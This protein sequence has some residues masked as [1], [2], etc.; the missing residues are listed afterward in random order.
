M[1]VIGF[2]LWVTM[3][4][5]LCASA[6]LKPVRVFTVAPRLPQVPR[7]TWRPGP[8]HDRLQPTVP[9]TALAPP[10]ASDAPACGAWLIFMVCASL[11]LVATRARHGAHPRCPL[12]SSRVASMRGQQSGR[13]SLPDSTVRGIASP[14]EGNANF[15]SSGK[16]NEA[17]KTISPE[18]AQSGIGQEILKAPWATL[19]D[20]VRMTTDAVLHGFTTEA[21]VVRASRKCTKQV[22]TLGPAVSD[23]SLIERLFLCGVDVFRLNLSHGTN[24]EKADLIHAIRR[25][26]VRYMHPIGI[27][28]DLQ[29]PKQRCG[30]FA[31]ARGTYLEVG[32]RFRFDLDPTPGDTTRV[33]LPH[34]EIL[35]ALKPGHILLL[36]DGK[37][38]T[39]V[40]RAGYFRGGEERVFEGSRELPNDEESNLLSFVDCEVEVGGWLGSRKGVNTPDVVLPISPLTAKDI[41]DAEFACKNGVDWLGLSFVQRHEDIEEL[42]NLVAQ[43]C[44]DD[45][46]GPRPKLLAKIEKPSAFRDIDRIIE[47]SDGVMVARGDLGVEISHED[48]P[49]VQKDIVLRAHAAGK[50]SIVATSMLESMIM[51]PAPTRAECSDIANAVLDGCDAVMLSGETAVGGFPAESVEMQRRVIEKAESQIRLGAGT[52]ASAAWQVSNFSAGA[53]SEATIVSAATLA[54]SV[55]AKAIVCFTDSGE[56]VRQ[57][58][59][60]RPSVPVLAFTQSLDCARRLSLLRGVYAT[61]AAHDLAARLLAQGPYSVRFT[62]ALVEACRW[63]R[64]R[65]VVIHEEDWLVVVA[66]LPP[67]SE[68]PLNTVRLVAATGPLGLDQGDELVGGA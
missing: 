39:R 41:S 45:P 43:C 31:V 67:F 59:R 53:P 34:P 61:T 47:A 40:V 66:K 54:Q 9:G 4:L 19:I 28:A 56:L 36:D 55:G 58:A 12:H 57:L 48:V 7:K 20:S 35:L 33:Q 49:F 65:G 1:E 6:I 23:E 44:S 52:G 5:G 27:L 46:L 21:P 3:V 63:A 8:H 25:V 29:G 15:A 38:Q 18:M 17:D 50:P 24:A 11:G 22:A 32:Q 30:M 14:T 60:I 2:R 13:R 51:C 62:E 16:L 26:E 10:L 68:G 37:I 42:R 64:E